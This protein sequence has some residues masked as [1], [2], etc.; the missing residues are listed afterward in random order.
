MPRPTIFISYSH[1]TP[2]HKQWV[3]ELALRLHGEGFTV[4]LDRFVAAPEEGWPRWTQNAI[5]ESDFVLLICSAG[6]R[7]PFEGSVTSGHGRGVSWEG[8]IANQLLYDRH[9]RNKGFIS[10]RLNDSDD[11]GMVP[12]PFRGFAGFALPKEYADLCDYI[13]TKAEPGRMAAAMGPA[14][15]PAELL[16]AS[17]QPHILSEGLPAETPVFV[18]SDDTLDTE[19]RYFQS[20]MIAP[21]DGV[22]FDCCVTCTRPSDDQAFWRIATFADRTLKADSEIFNPMDPMI[23]FIHDETKES[24]Y[25]T[26]KSYLIIKRR[27][28]NGVRYA[29]GEVLA[30]IFVPKWNQVHPA[31]SISR[32]TTYEGILKYAPNITSS[33]WHQSYGKRTLPFGIIAC[34]KSSDNINDMTMKLSGGLS[35]RGSFVVPAPL[36]GA[37]SFGSLG[38]SDDIERSLLG[39]RF[40]GEQVLFSIRSPDFTLGVKVDVVEGV[41]ESVRTKDVRWVKLS[42]PILGV[43]ITKY[44]IRSPMVGTFYR[45]EDPGLEPFAERGKQLTQGGTACIIEAL[46]TMNRISVPIAGK[47]IEVLVRDGQAVEYGDPLILVEAL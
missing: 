11:V 24:F 3:A 7:K 23:V 33:S 47:V 45:Q 16:P 41:I 44:W 43:R 37:L 12:F 6:Y 28:R 26:S 32:D 35:E 4:A 21:F 22:A 10:I 46:K 40:G 18:A 39:K 15:V 29:K 27:T 42:Q 31:W 1:D 13:R 20:E 19:N 38:V 14:A 9:S 25:F 2:A 30:D 34:G 17:S 5:L 36:D 8:L